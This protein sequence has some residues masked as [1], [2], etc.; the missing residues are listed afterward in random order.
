MSDATRPPVTKALW[1]TVYLLQRGTKY[2]L[3]IVDALESTDWAVVDEQSICAEGS[4]DLVSLKAEVDRRCE[5]TLSR[6]QAQALLADLRGHVLGEPFKYVSDR[7]ATV[8][9]RVVAAIVD[10]LILLPVELLRRFIFVH[11]PSISLRAIAVLTSLTAYLIYRVLMH[12][13][14][15]QTLGKMACGVVVLDV[16]ERPLSWR[17]AVLRDIFGIVSAAVFV[18]VEWRNLARGLDPYQTDFLHASSWFMRVGLLWFVLEILT[19]FANKKRRALHDFIAGSV[20]VR[21]S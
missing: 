9:P 18:I 7:Y 13:W 5:V 21:K 16:S 1:Y 10:S 11:S 2:R 15:G 19:L 17:Q 4:T 6:S 8:R 14:R 12:G 20:V 3:S